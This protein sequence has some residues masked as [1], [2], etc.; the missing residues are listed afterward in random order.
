MVSGLVTTR[1]PEDPLSIRREITQS[2]G[3]VHTLELEIS[4]EL[5]AIDEVNARFNAFAGVHLVPA[6]ARRTFNI[7]FDD[8]LN[9][10]ITYAYGGASDRSIDVRVEITRA[11]LEAALS[12][13]GPSFDPFARPAPDVDLDLDERELGGLGIHLVRSLMDEV[14]YRRE[15]DKNVV[16]LRKYL[17]DDDP[18]PQAR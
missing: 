3:G 18:T 10:I 15:S 16:V 4:S 17:G 6:G 12:D 9:N 5:D 13:D 7:A 14:S 1:R 11:H 2:T 8:L